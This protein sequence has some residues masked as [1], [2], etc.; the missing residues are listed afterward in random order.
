MLKRL[1]KQPTPIPKQ[2]QRF[3]YIP[4]LIT[5]RLITQHTTRQCHH[6]NSILAAI[7]YY[8]IYN[9]SIASMNSDEFINDPRHPRFAAGGKFI[10][11]EKKN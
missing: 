8:L 9:A 4:W 7:S 2:I 11:L 10:D 6:T 1:I 5:S 3:D